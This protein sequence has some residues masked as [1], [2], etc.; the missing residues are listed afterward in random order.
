[1]LREREGITNMYELKKCALCGKLFNSLGTSLCAPCSEQADRDF[2]K[3]RDFI[4]EAEGSVT[5]N[6]ILEGTGVAE[7]T[8]LYLMKTD[9]LSQ[10]TIKYEGRMKCAV[11]GAEITKGKLCSKCNAVWEAERSRQAAL[12]ERDLHAPMRTGNRMYTRDI[13]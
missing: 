6:E 4:Y 12:Q 11:C 3:V 5:V 10:K 13:R 9:R 2:L 8:V 1:M 7:K